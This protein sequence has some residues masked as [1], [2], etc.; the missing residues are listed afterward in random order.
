P[1]RVDDLIFVKA[2]APDGAMIVAEL[3]RPWGGRRF[4]ARELVLAEIVNAEITRELAGT[5]G[6]RLGP[7][8]RAVLRQLETGASEKEI[9][10]ALD[11]SPHTTHD[12]VKAIYRAY[13]VRARPELMAKIAQRGRRLRLASHA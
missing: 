12:H 8:R 7:R 3:Y 10:A 1:H 5:A 2:H 6:P 9:A 4:G 11:L 13:G